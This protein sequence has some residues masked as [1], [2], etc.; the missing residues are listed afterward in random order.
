[1]HFI[2]GMAVCAM[3]NRCWGQAGWPTWVGVLMM[4]LG[5]FLRGLPI[6][7]LLVLP[8]AIFFFRAWSPRPW[9]AILQNDGPWAPAL[10]RSLAIIPLGIA[11]ALIT[12]NP[13]HILPTCIAI[14]LI[15][16]VW[17]WSGFAKWVKVDTA[18]LA[19]LGYGT[20]LGMI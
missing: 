15:P 12:H 18:C 4:T 2:L 16:Y 5:L 17:R 9:M 6:W 10:I 14:P 8:G 19:E 11:M 1:M 13:I 20:V 7:S 3:G